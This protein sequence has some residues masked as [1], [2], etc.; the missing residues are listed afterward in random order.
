[1]VSK[2]PRKQRLAFYQAPLHRRHKQLA[3]P[4]SRELREKYGCRSL[5]VRKGDKVRVMRGDFTKLEG[6]VLKVDLKRRRIQ[7]ATMTVRKA[8]GTEVP[9]PVH[10]SNVM[11]L[12]LAPDKERDKI[13]ERKSK[14]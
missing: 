1:M 12:K 10:P 9:R 7:V 14:G 13:L 5:P 11:I 2:R 4:L 6:E 3:A 8:G